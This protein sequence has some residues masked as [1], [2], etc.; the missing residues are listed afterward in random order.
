MS[1]HT[2]VMNL[3]NCPR[4]NKALVYYDGALGY[5]SFVCPQC[6]WDVNEAKDQGPALLAALQE[7]LTD[8]GATCFR[9]REFAEQRINSITQIARR[10]I[11]KLIHESKT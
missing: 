9:S 1:F 11:A 3:P 7:C 5:E 2:Q 8:G 10:A 4:C 6:R